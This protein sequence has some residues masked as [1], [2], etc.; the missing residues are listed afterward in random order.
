M[1]DGARSRGKAKGRERRWV[2]WLW[3]GI[4]FL[5]LLGAL[6]ALV[7]W[8]L[9]TIARREIARLTNTTIEVVTSSISL[10]GAVEIYGL[11][12]RPRV[13]AD[14]DNA[15]LRARYVHAVFSKA[16]LFFLRP[17]LRDITVQDFVLNAQFDLDT[18]RWNVS[19]LANNIS[20]GQGEQRPR[21]SLK[22]GT[23]R[24]S[25][26]SHQM[27]KRVLAIPVDAL[28]ELDKMTE[29]GF[30]FEVKT[31]PI[32]KQLGQR[33]LEGYWKPGLV[34][35]TGAFSTQD[36][37]SLDR[38]WTIDAMAAQLIYDPAGD[39]EF[40]MNI[41]KLET[42][43]R[44]ESDSLSP[45]PGIFGKGN[46]PVARVQGFLDRYRPAGTIDL[47]RLTAE[48]NYANLGDS[49]VEGWADC[50]NVSVLDIKF[51]YRMDHLSGRIHFS[52][53]GWYTTGLK[54]QHDD[55]PLLIRFSRKGTGE[56][57]EFALHLSS[58]KMV[59]NEELY[60]ALSPRNQ[61]LWSLVNPSGTAGFE[62]DHSDSP[63]E[64][65]HQ[66]LSVLLKGTDVTY[67]GFP[68][69]LQ[70]LE[71]RAEFQRDLIRFIGVRTNGMAPEISVEGRIYNQT[72]ASPDYNLTIRA[73]GIPVDDTLRQALRPE[74]QSV[75]EDLKLQG[76]ID[77]NMVVTSRPADPGPHVAGDITFQGASLVLPYRSLA[78]DE[79]RGGPVAIG[80]GSVHI[81]DVQG[82]FGGDPVSVSGSVTF[83]DRAAL[84][85]YDLRIQSSR[86]SVENARKALG[87]QVNRSID[88]FS[89]SGNFALD[90]TIQKPARQSRPRYQADIRF[91]G[92]AVQPE[93]FPYPFT[94][95]TGGFTVDANAITLR[96]IVARPVTGDTSRTPAEGLRVDGR[97]DLKR[98]AMSTAEIRLAAPNW[99][100][101]RETLLALPPDLS[102]CLLNLAPTGSVSIDPGEIRL[103]KGQDG[104][105]RL[106]YDMALHAKDCRFE[107]LGTEGHYTGS[108]Q[109]NG[110][111]R[112]DEG[113][114][115]GVVT[116]NGHSLTIKEK[117][118][119]NV[120]A[121][122][123]YDPIERTWQSNDILADFYGGRLWGRLEHK[124]RADGTTQ[125]GL[126]LGLAQS[127]F[128]QFM[129]RPSEDF[130]EKEE[131][132]QGL[133]NAKLSLVLSPGGEAAR[134]GRCFFT[135]TD[136]R[137]GRAPLLSQLL[138]TLQLS[139][140]GDHPFDSLLVDG[141]INGDRLDIDKLDLSGESAAFW[142]SGHLNL[143]NENIDLQLSARGKRPAYA[144]PSVIQSLTERVVGAVM[145]VNITGTLSSP[146]VVP[147]ALPMI[148]DSLRRLNPPSH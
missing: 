29:Q 6:H 48:G 109:A 89:P 34:T 21:I 97:I 128:G 81:Q 67:R 66:A 19:D 14:Y 100:L 42:D 113:L 132:S 52:H 82:V 25:K 123:S 120:R 119:Q 41:L 70:N 117:T 93:A 57:R 43:R 1:K 105:V 50:S 54:G 51:P 96:D 27:E 58:D 68:Y 47:I 18:G 102:E 121:S 111:Y 86:L 115:K 114:E 72:T 108:F 112:S 69:P 142:G 147:Q 87:E 36:A 99:P 118:A 138:S 63:T 91:L 44:I 88:W 13:E 103:V 40:S 71:G 73:T 83:G 49:V 136:M 124:R 33:R 9:P 80:S 22:K 101:D 55:I 61:T 11:V 90:L 24:Y 35:L 78:V 135:I 139:G 143:L 127:D 94:D 146:R 30:K 45:I 20:G 75:L 8:N 59:L 104:T 37:P 95:L 140:P 137:V 126:Q 133:L 77:A 74:A 85:G 145:R 26:V 5:V 32:F 17:K 15:I 65:R 4:V 134:R 148:E 62:Y 92:T 98:G 28:F 2:R 129:A 106:S 56:D 12:V 38:V 79:L 131:A 76:T 60:N 116:M 16:S 141:Y 110:L 7:L 23:L 53:E 3:G 84:D 122:I 39:Y 46:D 64:G 144:K 107:A 31:G 130:L 125:L 10:D